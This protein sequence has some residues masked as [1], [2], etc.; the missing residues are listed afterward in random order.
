MLKAQS[1]K[2]VCRWF[3]K[4]YSLS[5]EQEIHSAERGY[6]E[7]LIF[8]IASPCK[9]SL[10]Y[11]QKTIF[12]M[13]AIR[14]LGFVVIIILHHGIHF[15]GPNIVLNFYVGWFCSFWHKCNII[16]AISYRHFSYILMDHTNLGLCIRGIMWPV[17]GSQ[18]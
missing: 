7:I 5:T 10:S 3:V 6:D 12:N 1:N 14:H 9:I 11:G 4:V 17:C 2:Q 16:C 18:I 13:V 15:H 8:S